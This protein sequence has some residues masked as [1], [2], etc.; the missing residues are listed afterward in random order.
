MSILQKAEDLAKKVGKDVE[1]LWAEF[2]A[3]VEGKTSDEEKAKEA[4]SASEA[5]AATTPAEP[6]AEPTAQAETGGTAA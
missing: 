6:A 3:F 5:P 4:P 1:T 2:E